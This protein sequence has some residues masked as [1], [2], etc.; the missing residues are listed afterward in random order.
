MTLYNVDGS[1]PI[2]WKTLKANKMEVS[3]KKCQLLAKSFWP[4]GLPYR[5]Q[6]CL[7]SAHRY[8]SLCLEIHLLSHTHR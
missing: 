2:S 8:V 1:R 4:A 7:A 5:F 3:R 6:T